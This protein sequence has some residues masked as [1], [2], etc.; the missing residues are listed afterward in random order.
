MIRHFLF[1][2]ILAVSGPTVGSTEI[3][4]ASGTPVVGG[5]FVRNLEAGGEPTTLHPIMATDVYADD[6]HNYVFDSLGR[7]DPKTFEWK[8]R[9]AEKWEISK[10][11][12]S[13]TFFL[14]KGVKFHDGQPLTA[15][16]VKFSFE[17]IFE[18]AYG[19]LDKIPYFESID[20]VEV[21]DPFTVKFTTKNTYFQNFNVVASFWILPKHVYGDVAKSKKMNR[22]ALGS[23]PYRLEKLQRGQRITLKRFSDWYGFTSPEW[24]NS[25]NFETVVLRFVSSDAVALEMAKKR[26]LDFQ[27][28]TA[29]Y[30]EKKTS[31]PAWGKTV[32]KNK[33]ENSEPKSFGFIGWNFRKEIFQDKNVR[34]GLAHLM[35]R[36]EMNNK[37]RFG[38]SRLATGPF[39]S[40]SDYAPSHV[41]PIPFDPKV[42]GEFLKKAGWTDSDQNGMLD[43]KIGE[44]LTEFRFTLVHSNRESEKY[45][46]MYKE[47]LKKAGIDMEIKY[48][49]WNSF[50]KM[51]D[52]GNFEA[53]AMAW[54]NPFEW[55]PKQIWHSTSAVQGGSNF[56]HYKNP[57]VDKLIDQARFEMDK[58]RRIKHLHKLYEMIADDAPYVW[59]FNERFAFYANSD[60]VLKA[61]DTLKYEIGTHYW[62]STLKK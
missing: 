57:E 20:K 35:N 8:P 25:H 44:K 49:E 11:G 55:D 56:I 41:K 51:V 28:L 4:A 5:T 12:K 50:I 13:F 6:V 14:R 52:E 23:G 59:M 19:A 24:K 47:D 53:V 7:R 36:E 16:D 22:E 38:H 9:I 30:Y 27:I 21:I 61:E 62:W 43:K 54:Q 37:F 42:A 34:L 58:S 48:L 2:L 26:E 10:D 29:E 39:Y 33:I 60:K 18:K 46:T 45:W 31:G 40:A 17:A 15:E 32:M 1:G 3:I